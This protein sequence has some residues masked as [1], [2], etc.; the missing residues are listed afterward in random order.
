MLKYVYGTTYFVRLWE[1]VPGTCCLFTCSKALSKCLPQSIVSYPHCREK[2]C[3]SSLTLNILVRVQLKEYVFI[4]LNRSQP[5][6][7]F[8]NTRISNQ[9]S[10]PWAETWLLMHV[11]IK[12]SVGC[13]WLINKYK[14]I[15]QNLSHIQLCLWFQFF[16]RQ[17]VFW[18]VRYRCILSTHQHNSHRH[19]QPNP[20]IKTSVYTTPHL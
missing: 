12:W 16:S 14:Y 15:L 13:D 1:Y 7:R 18:T 19:I 11:L 17:V 4:L 3:L 20:V 8:I 10:T 5:T 9:V 2:Y 6:L